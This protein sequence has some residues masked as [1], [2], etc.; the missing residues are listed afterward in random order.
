MKG[1]KGFQKGN[2]ITLGYKHT[3]KAKRKIGDA[4]R[5][6]KNP[7]KRPEVR[8]K[9]RKTLLNHTVSEKTRKIMKD[10]NPSKRPEVREKQRQKALE[11]FKNGMP[12]NT[13]KKISKSMS[14]EKHW[15]WQ[16]GKSYEPYSI[17]WTETLR[18]S[19][20]ERDHYI[21]QLCSQYGNIVHHKDY[22]KKNCDPKNLI[23]LCIRCNPK[24]NF[25]KEYWIRHF[26]I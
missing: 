22:N 13:K 10:D 20:R 25:N 3:S 5:G 17:D 23:T 12:E 26:N 15:N 4:K 24:V 21:C 6:D 16:D 1:I 2:A 18:R 8:E 11:Q 14:G 19:I 9:I 7:A